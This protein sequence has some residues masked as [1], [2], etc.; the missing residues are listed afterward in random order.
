MI[1]EKLIEFINHYEEAIQEI[2]DWA[3]YAS[4]YFQEKHGLKE[5]LQEH[6]LYLEELRKER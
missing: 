2:E 4:E 3:A 6:R 5:I 1:K